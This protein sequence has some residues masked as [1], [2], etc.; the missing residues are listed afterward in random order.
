MKLKPGDIVHYEDC[1]EEHIIKITSTREAS[2]HIGSGYVW[3]TGLL[4]FTNVDF[5]DGKITRFVSNEKLKVLISSKEEK[6]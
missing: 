2:Y 1:G 6:E 5:Y 3:V 4:L